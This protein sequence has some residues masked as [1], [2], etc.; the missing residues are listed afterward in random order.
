MIT[1]VIYWMC[2]MSLALFDILGK[3]GGIQRIKE[4]RR[5]R[6]SPWKVEGTLL[7]IKVPSV[8]IY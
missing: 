7:V 6:E 3:Q 1:I 2:P 4:G 5:K 8:A